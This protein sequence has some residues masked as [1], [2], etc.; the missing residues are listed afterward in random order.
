MGK[1]RVG[2]IFL[3][4]AIIAYIFIADTDHFTAKSFNSYQKINAKMP[5]IIGLLPIYFNLNDMD[6]HQK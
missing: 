6:D 4:L 5:L 2:V 3:F 1:T